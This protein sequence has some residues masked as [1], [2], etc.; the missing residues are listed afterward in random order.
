[1]RLLVE[2]EM[3]PAGGIV[4]AGLTSLTDAVTVTS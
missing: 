3:K 4:G 1:M 2:G